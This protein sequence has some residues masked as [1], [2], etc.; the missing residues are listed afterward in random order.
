MTFPIRKSLLVQLTSYFSLLSAIVIGVVAF[1]AYYQARC[2]LMKEVVDRLSATIALKSTQLDG[3]VDHQIQD[4]L[5]VS[6]QPPVQE[7]VATLLMTDESEATYQ[8]TEQALRR[9]IDDWTTIKSNLHNIRI[10]DT[11]STVI[12][13]AQHPEIKGRY[14]PNAAPTT[15]FT[16]ETADAISP[17]FYIS[18]MTGQSAIT[19][20]TP[21]VDD[22][23]IQMGAIAVDLDLADI[24]TLIRNNTGLGE[25]AETYLV[26]NSRQGAIFISI[27]GKENLQSQAQISS[28]GIDL[29]IE[30]QNGFGLYKNYA[31]IPVVGVYRWLPNQEL[32]LLAE[33]SQA[34]AFTPA[35]QLARN[36]VLIGL[37]STGVLLVG[38]YLLSREIVR[39]IV[40]ICQAAE[41]LAAGDLNQTAPVI[42]KNEVGR[43][44]STFNQMA[45][46][47]KESFSTL[48]QRVEERTQDLQENQRV[49]RTLMSNLPG[50]AY[51]CL[52]DEYWTMKFVS[53]G[54]YDLTGYSSED[55]IDNR[56]I[57]YS[58][59]IDPR[60]RPLVESTMEAAIEQHKPFQLV[61]RCITATGE[62]KWFWEQG[63]GVYTEEGKITFIEGFITDISERKQVEEALAEAKRMSDSAN[64]AKSEFLANMSHEL[65]T[66]LNGILG[67]AQILQMSNEL[68][69]KDRK[70]VDVIRQAGTHL[71]TLI[72]DVLD[73]AK[74][75]ARK[76]ELLPETVNFS[77]FLQSVAEVIC[78]KAD[79]KSLEFQLIIPSQLPEGVYIDPKRLRQVLLNLL[80]NSIK[81]THQGKVTLTVEPMDLPQ[82]SPELDT[83]VM[84]IRFTVKD[85]GIGMT[86]EHI[87]KIFLPF[88]QVGD[89]QQK[90]EGTG[91]GLAISHQIVEMMRGEIQV[92]SE[93]DKGSCFW[94][95]VNLPLVQD[96]PEELSVAVKGKIVG[97][98]GQQRKVLIVDDKSINRMV[99]REALEIMGF[100]V[101]EAEDGEQGIEEYQKF[102]PDLIITDLIMPKLDGFELAC[103]IRQQDSEVTIV[104][105]SASLLENDKERSIIAGCNDFVPKPVDMKQLLGRIQKLLELEWIYET[106]M[107][108]SEAATSELIYPPREQLTD[109]KELAQE[110][111]ITGVEEEVERLRGKDS[112]YGVFCDRILALAN[113]F[114]DRGIVEFLAHVI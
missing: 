2:A 57:A 87:E 42:T 7:A 99:V 16:S 68:S 60:D 52:H 19:F 71:L 111:D 30:G 106:S 35:R 88:E 72:N 62:L 95:E 11:G 85:T 34:E 86:P 26:G 83:T 40:A 15:F 66:P 101:A 103:R 3:W 89:R 108:P 38:V 27:E 5:L 48:E 107:T 4:I 44:A 112:K 102:Q 77:L 12:F 10:T 29:A 79:Q 69:Q 23:N 90:S 45:G 36:I 53:Q 59:L 55:L 96:W 67:Y 92:S 14:R 39:P 54:G 9:Y 109:L 93:L 20:A 94:F 18:P 82:I 17:Y 49:L 33:I 73:L 110:S 41:S 25:T 51:R 24:D 74:I 100:V 114:D 65:R 61:Y 97:Y 43:L 81:F 76:L 105:S 91:L 78:I 80:S 46:Q 1:S 31:D 64:Q 70:G 56:T 63:T 98:N 104:V 75:E 47:L 22:A 84:P 50:M 21:I 37:C 28:V 6:Q 8:E 32:A 13:D 113:E 58:D